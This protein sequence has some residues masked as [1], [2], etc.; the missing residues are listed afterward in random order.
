MSFSNQLNVALERVLGPG[1]EAGLANS[2]SKELGTNHFN[3]PR[4]TRPDT[5]VATD[6]IPLRKS[7]GIPKKRSHRKFLRANAEQPGI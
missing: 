5:T 4:L 6:K 2:L 1:P 7:G 3:L